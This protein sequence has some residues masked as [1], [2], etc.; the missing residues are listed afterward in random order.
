MTDTEKVRA[1]ND[2]IIGRYEY[3]YSYQSDSAYS[4]LKS[5][6]T[7]CQGYSMTAYKMLT[8][9]G[10]KNRI[11]VGSVNGISHSWNYIKINNTWFHLDITNNDA[12]RSDK[13]FLV[14]DNILLFNKY[15]WDKNK[16]SDIQ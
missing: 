14:G 10:V 9:A 11:V 8:Y 4:A 5:G 3:D 6:L 2:Y 15:V 12:T 7:I 1:I 13:Y 16:Y